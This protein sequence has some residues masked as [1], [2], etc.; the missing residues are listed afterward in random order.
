LLF[1]HHRS[2]SN[3]PRKD[4]SPVEL[5]AALLK[6]IESVDDKLHCFITLTAD[7]ALRQ[8][9]QAEQELRSGKDRGPLHGIPITLKDLYMTQGIRTTCHSAVLENWVPAK[10]ATAASKLRDAGAIL[11]G[12]LGMHEFAFGGPSVDAA[13]KI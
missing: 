13:L 5:T 8:A 11:L 12:K 10:D 7:L 1:N 6:R 3:L 4:F 2:R 9:K